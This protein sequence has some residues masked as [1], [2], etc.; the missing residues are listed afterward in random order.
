[1]PLLLTYRLTLL[2][3]VDNKQKALGLKACARTELQ[4]N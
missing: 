3:P 2:N 4:Y 1:L